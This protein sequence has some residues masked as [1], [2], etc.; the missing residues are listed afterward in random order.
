MSEREALACVWACEKWHKYLWGRDFVLRT[1]HAALRTLITAKGIGRA[2][3]RMSRWAARLMTYSFSV[4][5]LKGSRNPA[6]GLSRLPGPAVE[7]E[8]DESQLVAV[9]STR[10]KAVSEAELVE[11][12][13][14][15]PVM[16]ML[17]A[18]LPQPWPGRMRD[19]P[20]DL[21]PFYR[22]RDELSLLNGLIF[23]GERVVL[24]E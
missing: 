21:Q 19:V 22:C 8:D 23:K 2:G 13:R 4:Q 3:M 20:S 7:V 12:V 1:D 16:T 14:S 6:D 24:P 9:L 15:D 5:H 11:A 10:L 17:A 18:Q